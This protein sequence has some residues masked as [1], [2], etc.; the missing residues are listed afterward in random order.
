MKPLSA[1]RARR[2]LRGMTDERILVLGDVMLDEFVW[3]KVVRISP[4]APVPVVEVTDHSFHVG[5]AGNVAR[6]VR[7]LGGAAILAGVVG[8]D[9][10]AERIGQELAA[11][12][13]EATLAVSDSGR[14]TT[15]KT[16]IIAH[17]QQVVR[18]DREQADDIGDAL[19]REV[20]SRA[21]RALPR[22]RAVV[23]SDY[24][25]GVVTPRVMR[26]VLSLARRRRIPVFVDPK[27]D[28]LPLYRGV[29]VLTP[30]QLE[31]EQATG[32]RIRSAADVAAAGRHLL[33]T[34][35][36]RAALLTRGEHGMC[37]VERGKAPVHIPTAAREV[38][39]VTGAGDT[40]IATL[41]LAFCAGAR[42]AEAAM[43]ANY[44][45]GVAVG[46]LGTATVTPDE[47]LAA[48]RQGRP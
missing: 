3:G 38:F 41:A 27:V 9:G 35:S 33:R 32:I 46:K 26:E 45:A 12:G 10:A 5:G 42:L 7:S 28:H 20:L 29:A 13:V 17:H 23:V 43:L 44:A 30:N 14:P 25:K 21:R 19:E 31:A 1:D 4:E 11:A 34:L 47:V 40:V 18:A 2:I 36:C 39:D 24:R 6:N 37:L 22:C 16:R 48:V 15:V 8:R